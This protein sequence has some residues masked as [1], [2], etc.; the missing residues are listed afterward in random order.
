MK[1]NRWYHFLILFLVGTIFYFYQSPG[2]A[3]PFS[4]GFSEAVGAGLGYLLFSTIIV[5]IPATIYRLKKKEWPAWISSG[6]AIAMAVLLYY[7]AQ[8]FAYNAGLSTANH[9]ASIAKKGSSGSV[10]TLFTREECELGVV[11]PGGPKYRIIHAPGDL[12]FHEASYGSQLEFLKAECGDFS[13]LM[14]G[15]SIEEINRYWVQIMPG[16]MEVEGLSVP[17]VSSEIIEFNERPVGLITGRAYK[18]VNGVNL[19][20]KWHVLAT[21][22]SVRILQAGAPASRFPTSEVTSFLNGYRWVNDL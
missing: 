10:P 5:G 1:K 18:T 13:Q 14:G 20:H 19:I 6:A 16:F 2:G 4:I 12:R 17:Q 21:D 3:G 9:G 22:K 11:F 8:G 7:S 15:S